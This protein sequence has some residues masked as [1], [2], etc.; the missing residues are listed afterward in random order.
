MPPELPLDEPASQP[1]ADA[2]ELPDLRDD[3]SRHA[4]REVYADERIKAENGRFLAH[5][6]SKVE[7]GDGAFVATDKEAVSSVG[8]TRTRYETRY[9]FALRT[10]H[11]VEVSDS[12]FQQMLDPAEVLAKKGSKVLAADSKVEAGFGSYVQARQG[13]RVSALE[14]STVRAQEGSTTFAKGG[15]RVIAEDGSMVIAESGARIVAAEGSRVTAK[16]GSIIQALD[17]AVVTLEEP[18]NKF[19]YEPAKLTA[20]KG[21]RIILSDP[22]LKFD[23]S[24]Q[25]EIVFN[26]SHKGLQLLAKNNPHLGIHFADHEKATLVEA[27]IGDDRSWRRGDHEPEPQPRLPRPPVEPPAERFPYSSAADAILGVKNK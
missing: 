8:T 3:W 11:Q 10:Y 19:E 1:V 17:G 24:M 2:T 14:G 7:A 6:G 18:A 27:I 12:A 9:N 21:A 26:G 5:K 13:S 16:P 20:E 4:T 22:F 23:E 15:S 25:G